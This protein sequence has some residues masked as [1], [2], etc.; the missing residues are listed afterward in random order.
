MWHGAIKINNQ[1]VLMCPGAPECGDTLEH[2]DEPQNV[3]TH[4]IMWQ[5]P[6]PMNMVMLPR[7]WL[8]ATEQCGDSGAAAV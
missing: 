4:L 3:T 6:V 8:H 1:P 5:H 7:T 2:G